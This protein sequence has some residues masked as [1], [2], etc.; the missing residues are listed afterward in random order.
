MRLDEL[1]RILKL[2]GGVLTRNVRI[3]ILCVLLFWMNNI[4]ELLT[5]DRRLS[6]ACLI[7]TSKYLRIIA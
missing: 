2:V 7:I 1:A 5:D 4:R 3:K 6:R